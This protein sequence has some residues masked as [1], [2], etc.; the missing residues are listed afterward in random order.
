M[1]A[2]ITEKESEN[3]LMNTV[4]S[5]KVCFMDKCACQ[6]SADKELT[7]NQNLGAKHLAWQLQPYYI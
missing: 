5:K 1:W 4:R 7:L 3:L 2:S 6:L